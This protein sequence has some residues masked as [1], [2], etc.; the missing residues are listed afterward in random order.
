MKI[1]AFILSI[2]FLALDFMPCNDSIPITED[3]QI[4]AF[5]DS[6]ENHDHSIE[7]D[8]CSPFCQCHCCHVHVIDF[9]IDTYQLISPEISTELF[10]HFDSVG[11][12]ISNTLFQPPQV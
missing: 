1:L 7:N 11:K 8:L 3:S 9:S 2:Y 4:E 6:C 5:A 10:A 12:E